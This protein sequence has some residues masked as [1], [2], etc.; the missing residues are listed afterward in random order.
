M[1]LV[2]THIVPPDAPR[3]RLSDYLP[4]QLQ[5][6]TS[7]KGIKK[8]IKNGAVEVDGQMGHTGDWVNPGQHIKI[9]SLDLTPPRPLDIAIETIYEDDHLIAIHKPAGL[10]VSGNQ[11]H[12]V[13]NA[14][15]GQLSTGDAPDAL[16]WPQAVHRLDAPTSGLLLLAKTHRS[17]V[18]LGH[19]FAERQVHKTYQAIVCGLAKNKGHINTPIEDKEALTTYNKIKEA[20]SLKCEWLSLLELQPHTG[21]THQLRRHLASIGFP[22]LGDKQYTPS[23]LPLLK[24]KGLFLCAVKLEFPHPIHKTPLEIKMSAPSKFEIMLQRS[25]NRWEKFN[26]EK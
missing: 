18:S 20:R 16:P 7:R 23:N 17:L 24:Q 25:Q 12:T 9:Y 11:Y 2:E 22:I 10:A 4:G 8:A 6:I 19:I 13:N 15:Q 5:F 21:R 3:L 26:I 14:I 1:R